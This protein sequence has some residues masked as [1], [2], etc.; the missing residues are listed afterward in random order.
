[1]GVGPVDTVLASCH[2]GQAVIFNIEDVE[3]TLRA[4]RTGK[5]VGET[6][7]YPERGRLTYVHVYPRRGG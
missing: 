1:M 5:L 7:L 6:V 4:R 3:T 2:A